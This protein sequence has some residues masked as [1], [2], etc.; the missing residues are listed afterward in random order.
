MPSRE[1]GG[2]FIVFW[3]AISKKLLTSFQKYDTIKQ[4]AKETFVSEHDFDHSI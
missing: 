2:F 1:C 3:G 4:I